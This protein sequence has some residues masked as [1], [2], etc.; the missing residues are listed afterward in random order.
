MVTGNKDTMKL[1]YEMQDITLMLIFNMSEGWSNGHSI[2]SRVFDCDQDRGEVCTNG[3]A[4]SM[5]EDMANCMINADADKLRNCKS[6][7]DDI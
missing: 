3:N 2:A 5:I 7:G 4:L 1:I 6:F